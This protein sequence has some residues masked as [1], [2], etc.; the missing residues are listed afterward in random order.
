MNAE[1][2]RQMFVV[3]GIAEGGKPLTLRK[4]Y[5]HHDACAYALAVN[6]DKWD[7]IWVEDVIGQ[8]RE[9][10]TAPPPFPWSVLWVDGRAYVTDSDGRKI[11]TLLG[12]QKQREFVSELL[13]DNFG[14]KNQTQAA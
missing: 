8:Y 11:A 1:L 13:I 10:P 2:S 7:D 12:T 6:M 5:N 9:E 3:K 4:F 14:N